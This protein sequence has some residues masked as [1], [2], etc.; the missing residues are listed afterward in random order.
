ML[1]G[2][3]FI[4]IEMSAEYADI[5]R[6]RIEACISQPATDARENR[7]QKAKKRVAIERTVPQK[8]PNKPAQRAVEDERQGALF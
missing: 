6:R 7:V 2:F 8:A 5:A 3:N 1:E 4:G